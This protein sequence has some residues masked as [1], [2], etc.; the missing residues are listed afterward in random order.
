MPGSRLASDTDSDP[1]IP[2]KNPGGGP[3][4]IHSHLELAPAP[5]RGRVV[6]NSLDSI[7]HPGSRRGPDSPSHLKG[8]HRGDSAI[9]QP[10][11]NVGVSET[12][13]DTGLAWIDNI[14]PVQL[15]LHVCGDR[16]WRNHEDSQTT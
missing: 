3:A 2:E 15:V 6:N 10:G 4:T 7:L 16:A 14:D 11:E 5:Q 8:R 9:E 1:L 13:P 12:W